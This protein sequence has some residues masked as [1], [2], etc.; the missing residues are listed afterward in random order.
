MS[1]GA[2][3]AVTPVMDVADVRIGRR[4]HVRMSPQAAET[5]VAQRKYARPA[6][7]KRRSHSPANVRKAAPVNARNPLG[8]NMNRQNLPET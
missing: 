2:C 4:L 5:C 8:L 3:R 1:S 6:A 7:R